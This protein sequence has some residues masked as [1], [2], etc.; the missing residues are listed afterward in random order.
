MKLKNAP[1]A[2]AK[3]GVVLAILAGAAAL[4]CSSGVQSEAERLEASSELYPW[5]SKE[6][7]K[8]EEHRLWYGQISTS[9]GD[10][11]QHNALMLRLCELERR[12]EKIQESLD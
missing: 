4:A 6:C 8:Q 7:L 2:G 1:I 9:R 5:A 11:L 10:N 12:M 3:A